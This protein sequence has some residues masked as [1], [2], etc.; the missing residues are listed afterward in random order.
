MILFIALSSWNGKSGDW[1][2]TDLDQIPRRCPDCQRD[3]IIGHGQRKRQTHDQTHAWIWVR[4]GFCRLCR[5][6]FTFLPTCCVARSRYSLGCWIEALQQWLQHRSAEVVAPAM[7][8]ED[9]FVDPS[10]VRRWR[11]RW[12]DLQGRLGELPTQLAW[13]CQQLWDRLRSREITNPCDGQQSKS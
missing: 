7:Q 9:R 3:S 5:M 4:R 12:A 1:S 2:T 6:T 10:T 11:R 13:E 8:E